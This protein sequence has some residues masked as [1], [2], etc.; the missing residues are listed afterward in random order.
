MDLGDGI[1]LYCT[2]E[3]TSSPF[4]LRGKVYSFELELKML[5]CLLS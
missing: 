2:V 1:L 4:K 5:Y 3:K